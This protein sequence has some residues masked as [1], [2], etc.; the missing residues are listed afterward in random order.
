LRASVIVC[1]RNRGDALEECLQ[2]LEGQQLADADEFEIVVVDNGSTDGTSDAVRAWAAQDPGRRMAVTEP[3][4][5]LSRARNR[6]L[7][8]ATGDVVAF[9]DDDASASPGWIAA[10]LAAYA[11]DPQAVAVGGPIRLTWPSGR[12]DWLTPGL[13]HWFSALDFG[14]QS[15]PWPTPHGPYG[16]NMSV[17]RADLVAVGGFAD[18]L[19]RRGSS[20][21][22]SEE[23]DLFD[24]L[25]P[26]GG[27][28][29]YEPA[30]FVEHRVLA[31]R[32]SRSWV[33]RRG[34]AQ[35]RSNARVRARRR[36]IGGH[37]LADI[38][39]DEAGHA[40]RGA[41]DV[42]DA[43]RRRDD[44]TVVDEVARRAGHV[45]GA[46]EQIRLWLLAGRP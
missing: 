26:L 38:C 14:D 30:A 27:I 23:Q 5:G 28:V 34:W 33:L 19:G 31:D 22:S 6:G 3:S 2:S 40:V 37:E 35:G 32:I 43:L 11:R 17:R 39:R 25:R 9:I 8:A 13:E 36:E 18:S 46:L 20:L 7:D 1:T 10:H 45:S 4:P 12:P 42:L 21:I 41:E 24:R 16:T 15:Q 44:S 29:V